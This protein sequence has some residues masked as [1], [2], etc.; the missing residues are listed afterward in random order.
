MKRIGYVFLILLAFVMFCAKA[1]E[2]CASGWV[3]PPNHKLNIDSR[4]LKLPAGD[5]TIDGS[6]QMSTGSIE[7]GGNWT[8]NSDGL[9]AGAGE[10]KFTGS[11]QTIRGNNT[12]NKFTGIKPGSTL[13]F[14]EGKTQIIQSTWTLTGAAG[15]LLKLRSASAGK[16]WIVKPS[17]S[18][19]ISSVDVQDSNNL[20]LPV[21]DPAGSNNSGNTTNWFTVVVDPTPTATTAPGTPEPATPTPTPTLTPAPVTPT[22]S[23]ILTPVPEMPIPV[24][25]APTMTPAPV[26]PTPTPVFGPPKAEFEAD[27]LVGIIPFTVQFKDKSTNIPTGWVWDFGDGGK[28]SEQNPGHTYEKVDN[29]TIA[30][31][32]SN[33][34][35]KST[36]EKLDYISSVAPV[37]DEKCEAAF[38]A[39][40]VSG[41]A[42]LEVQFTD[43][44]PGE[45]T[46]WAWDFGD[47]NR[48]SQQNPKHIYQ[49]GEFVVTLTVTTDCGQGPKQSSV[50][51]KPPISVI[52]PDI[53]PP[54]ADFIV[55]PQSGFAE[56]NVQFTSASF[57]GRATNFAWTFGDGD[58]SNR[59]NPEHTYINP[60]K[61]TPSLFISNS[62]GKDV[63]TKVEHI[64]ILS[65]DKPVVEFE[66]NP[67]AGFGPLAVLF[68]DKSKGNIDNWNWEFGDGE[69]SILQNPLH[70]YENPGKYTVKLTVSGAQGKD[71]KEK[72][73]LIEAIK[74]KGP[75]AAFTAEP[76][77]GFKPLT[78]TFTDQ[79]SGN[80]SNWVWEFGDGE[81]SS[82]QHPIHTYTSSGSFDV[83]LTVSERGGEKAELKRDNV[84]DVFSGEGI[85][86]AFTADTRTRSGN[87]AESQLEVQF[88]D[89]S[90]S[91]AGMVD[92][93]LWDF[94]DGAKSSEKD[95]K[96]EYI[97]ADDDERFTVSLTVVDT[98]DNVDTRT[99]PAFIS[100]EEI[101]GE[102][103]VDPDPD[104]TETETE[105]ETVEVT[106]TE[107]VT[108]APGNGT[109]PIANFGA[110]ITKGKA[111]LVVEFFDLSGGFPESWLWDFGDG[112][113]TSALQNPSHTYTKKGSY[114]VMLTVSNKSGINSITKKKFI[115]VR[116]GK[117]CAASFV[118][119]NG[120][121]D[122]GLSILRLFRDN[123]MT[124][125]TTGLKL[126]TYYYKYS[127][128]VI[129]IIN[130]D[131]VLKSKASEVLTRLIAVLKNNLNQENVGQV[132]EGSIADS[133]ASEI[134]GLLDQI[135]TRGSDELKAAIA[136]TRGLVY[137]E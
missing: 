127:D 48:S 30:L 124:K 36:N 89:I 34:K 135:S 107:T 4:T 78:T 64:E 3:I 69:K 132:V 108:P 77:I 18:R 100:C 10:V 14:E 12:F 56:L 15:N 72:K 7:V 55:D 54:I 35:G 26:T 104:L 43:L 66:A 8:N 25:P 21:I 106:E 114:D 125:T 87:K 83:K 67:Q 44:T 19:N 105:T 27:R 109:A 68:T 39:K 102:L 92:S 65:A 129:G 40:P 6:I 126:I 31:T 45:T 98:K 119:D 20:I 37:D 88:K 85:T 29:Y 53:D 137:G 103:V 51:G 115:D 5:V 131:P 111:P 9:I 136:K 17:G 95:P 99:K 112:G 38:V 81:T 90:S 50:I 52:P 16:Q 1:A 97:C 128:E 84:I 94:G 75:T 123:V 47:G 101:E 46:S 2:L 86:A 71:T 116:K 117:V 24:T 57:G 118:I 11:N 58:T 73:D 93:W 59:E 91:S 63:E 76:S 70:V 120:E 79:S 74:G 33:S 62:A 49:K 41:F 23:P 134:N 60:G 96:H 82:Q 122:N 61:Y 32:V 13:I 28:S 80:V 133:L 110:D 113:P 22:P 130:S 42:P 121:D